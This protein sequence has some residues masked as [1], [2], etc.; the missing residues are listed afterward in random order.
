[1]QAL[2][3]S[4]L[5]YARLCLVAV[6]AQRIEV[7]ADGDPSAV[8]REL[9]SLQAGQHGGGLDQ[10]TQDTE[11]L[12]TLR[13]LCRSQDRL[14][15]VSD[16]RQDDGGALAQALRP[17]VASV[18][19]W[20]VGSSVANTALRSL[21]ELPDLVAGQQEH[22]DLHLGPQP[23]TLLAGIGSDALAPLPAQSDGHYRMPIPPLPPGAHQVELHWSHP[24]LRDWQ[25]LSLPLVS[26]APFPALLVSDRNPA[27]MLLALR[28][29][30]EHI[31]AR[32]LHP[33]QLPDEV[34]P[35]RGLLVLH[36]P[37]SD[38]Q[39]VA[40]WV[41]AGG[42]LWA[43]LQLLHADPVL[44]ALVP[45]A[46]GTVPG[47]SVRSPQP[48]VAPALA[49]H[50]VPE[51]LDV[52]PSPPA[53]AV[54]LHAGQA[55]LLIRSRVE[56][57][58]VLAETARLTSD[59][60]FWLQVAAGLWLR[61]QVRDLLSP[62]WQALLLYQGSSSP[63]DLHL[64]RSGQERSIPAG[65]AVEL[66]PGIWQRRDHPQ[67]VAIFPDPV[68]TDLQRAPLRAGELAA[69]LPPSA[70]SD[71]GLPL[72]IAALLVLL[73]E[74]GLAAATAGRYALGAGDGHA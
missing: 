23:E 13:E 61:D 50:Q 60:D 40:D 51:V 8:R 26:R 7:L 2:T 39:R 5:H 16:F 41:R 59:P 43:P 35:E 45:E 17:Q 10:L 4:S 12:A 71:W 64:L 65:A 20:Q 42:V 68:E 19:F 73:A 27:H 15:L 56:D 30:H 66:A 55:P 33:T 47:G 11:A 25:R 53:E 36:S 52:Q 48:A 31:Q 18:A 72:A 67:P 9:P 58:A 54:L 44:T 37:I 6:S 28:S 34:L 49:R 46:S 3:D 57:G 63:M 74:A 69:A 14:V 62:R 38:A 24:G 21:P 29:A 1:K 22:L 32:Q 70:G